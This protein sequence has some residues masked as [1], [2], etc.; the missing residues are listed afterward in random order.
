[1]NT[2]ARR[3]PTPANLRF[4]RA[5]TTLD[6]IIYRPITDAAVLRTEIVDVRMRGYAIDNVE[7]EDE[8]A[9]F[10]APVMDHGRRPVCSISVA[11]PASRNLPNEETTAQLVM[12]TARTISRRLGYRE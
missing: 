3:V 6:E 11:G 9:C 12:D 10:A 1:M 4:R 5:R 8:V 7:N 2:G